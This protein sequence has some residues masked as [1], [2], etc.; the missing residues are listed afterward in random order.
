MTRVS[1]L[2][3]ETLTV[4]RVKPSN[5]KKYENGFKV[6]DR[7]EPEFKVIGNM[8]P[9]TGF[10][11]LKVEENERRRDPHWLWT[12]TELRPNDIILRNGKQYEVMEVQDWFQQRLKHFQCRVVRRDV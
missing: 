3:D 12:K 9:I 1:L 6:P 4:K 7:F 11:L 8:Q 10:E 2:R 5:R